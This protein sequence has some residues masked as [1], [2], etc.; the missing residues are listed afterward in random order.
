MAMFGVINTSN[1]PPPLEPAMSLAHATTQ[2][3]FQPPVGPLSRP[4]DAVT[5]T[6]VY[7]EDANQEPVAYNPPAEYGKP[8]RVGRFASFSVQVE[9]ARPRARAVTRQTGICP[10]APWHL[11]PELPRRE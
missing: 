1:N 6:V 2:S 9:N 8:S 4:L 11:G 10:D 3:H 7:L 5:G